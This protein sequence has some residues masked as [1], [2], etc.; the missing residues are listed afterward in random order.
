MGRPDTCRC[1]QNV[2]LVCT[3]RPA[4]LRGGFPK[5]VHSIVGPARVKGRTD[6]GWLNSIPNPHLLNARSVAA[7]AIPP[8]TSV[9]RAGPG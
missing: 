5:Q 4:L 2:Q 7:T 8:Q 9:P 1:F 3:C 6:G